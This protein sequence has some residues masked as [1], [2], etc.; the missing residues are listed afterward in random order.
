MVTSIPS[1]TGVA[2]AGRSFSL[3]AT[4]TR[5]IRQFPT[6][7]SLGY[8]HSVGICT[9]AARAASRMVLSWS[10]AKRLPSIVTFGMGKNMERM[11]R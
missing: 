5:Q 11:V 3:P 7:G 1:D 9:P 6:V 10:T 2:H 4:D 8:Q